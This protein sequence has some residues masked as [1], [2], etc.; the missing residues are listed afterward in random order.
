MWNPWASCLASNIVPGGP[1]D[2]DIVAGPS[3]AVGRKSPLAGRS[4]VCC[5][6]TSAGCVLGL[7]V[8]NPGSPD[9]KV[10]SVR[11]ADGN[12]RVPAAEARL[13]R[14]APEPLPAEAVGLA[15]GQVAAL[16]RELQRPGVVAGTDSLGRP[17]LL[18]G[19]SRSR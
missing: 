12:W 16:R 19:V 3:A 8:L 18:V 13:V 10:P 9:H 4:V 7:L 2:T 14:A 17:G 5:G 1:P 15:P 11:G 6:V